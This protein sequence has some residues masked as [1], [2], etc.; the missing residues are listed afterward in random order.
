MVH[1]DMPQRINGI[2]SGIHIFIETTCCV[3]LTRIQTQF[4][5]YTMHIAH[6]ARYYFDKEKM[7]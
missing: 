1:T 3:F 2:L 5:N 6:S 4:E 7:K